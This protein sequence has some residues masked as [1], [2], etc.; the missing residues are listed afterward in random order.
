MKEGAW[1][2]AGDGRW[3]WMTEHATWLQVPEHARDLGLSDEAVRRI[4][5]IQW[6]F[7]G[8]GREAICL[9][10]MR[11]GLIRF[12]GHGAYVTFESVLPLETVLRATAAFMKSQF[13]PLTAIR[14]NRLD[15]GEAWAGLFPDIKARVVQ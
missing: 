14:I 9:E 13:G 6:D 4:Q 7:N 5:T 2:V 8:S 12:R 15:T 11:H 10:G 1:I 3:T